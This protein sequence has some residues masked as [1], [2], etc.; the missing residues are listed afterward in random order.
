MAERTR[1]AENKNLLDSRLA[2]GGIVLVA[3]GFLMYAEGIKGAAVVAKVGVVL[4]GAGFAW[5][6]ASKKH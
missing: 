2:K 4:F 5:N 3:A 1:G 6:W